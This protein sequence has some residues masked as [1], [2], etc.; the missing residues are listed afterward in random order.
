MGSWA[1]RPNGNV[2]RRSDDISA[3]LMNRQKRIRVQ[4]R[5]GVICAETN[6][7]S[8]GTAIIGMKIA[9][10]KGLVSSRRCLPI[11]AISRTYIV[12]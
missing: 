11:T 1:R 7:T 8:C 10:A 4:K 12:R 3:L 5:H 6:P 2:G 9:V